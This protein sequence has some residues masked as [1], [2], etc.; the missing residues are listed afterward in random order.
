MGSTP[1]RN[2]TIT[3]LAVTNLKMAPPPGATY[4]QT[5]FGYVMAAD[6]NGNMAPQNPYDVFST[7][8]AF[9]YLPSTIASM[10][11]TIAANTGDISTLTT[12]QATNTADISTL[13]A[14]ISTAIAVASTAGVNNDLLSTALTQYSISIV[15]YSTSISE[16]STLAPTVYDL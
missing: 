11:S 4:T 1:I 14:S 12:G 7:T 8:G 5:P 9:G 10:Q 13:S 3:N 16:F 6:S 2:E 15:L